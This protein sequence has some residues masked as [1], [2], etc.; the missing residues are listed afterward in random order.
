MDLMTHEMTMFIAH[1]PVNDTMK[2]FDMRPTCKWYV[3]PQKAT[4][5]TKTQ[6]TP[7]YFE[8]II[9]KSHEKYE[10]IGFWI[11]AIQYMGNFFRADGVKILSD[12]KRE[13]FL[14]LGEHEPNTHVT[15]E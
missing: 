4:F 15:E 11:P 8:N 10:E 2:A 12:G 1:R 6:I 9:A 13:M 7:G 14:P 5:S 3:E